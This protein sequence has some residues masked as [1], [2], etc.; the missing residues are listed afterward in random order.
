[1]AFCTNC[2]NKLEN[3]ELLCP[4]C[5]SYQERP[6]STRVDGMSNGNAL[7]SS[8]Q[9]PPYQ[10]PGQPMYQQP[11]QQ[12]YQNYQPQAPVDNGGFGWG[13]LGCCVPVAGLVLY[14]IWKDQKPR[15]AKAA[16]IGALVSV[17]IAVVYYIIIIAFGVTAGI[18]G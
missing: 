11:P 7:E 3:D 5:N 14:L 10:Q 15:T 13:L 6:E 4:N 18:F 9:Q 8:Y 16:G 12:Q 1:M 2:G 17:A